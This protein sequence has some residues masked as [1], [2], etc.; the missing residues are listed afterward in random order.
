MKTKKS[1]RKKETVVNALT[2]EMLTEKNTLGYQKDYQISWRKL[3]PNYYKYLQRYRL[4][5]KNG[6]FDGTFK[7]WQIKNGVKA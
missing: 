4:D 1:L 3:H 2:T 6:K 7:E 5:K